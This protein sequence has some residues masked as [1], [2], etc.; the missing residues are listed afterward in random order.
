[1]NQK[2]FQHFVCAAHRSPQ[3]DRIGD[4]AAFSSL[5]SKTLFK[6]AISSFQALEMEDGFLCHHD[7]L[8]KC[9][10]V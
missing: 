6:E 7:K 4:Y 10:Q 1:M 3:S 2:T 8:E 5:S 9:N